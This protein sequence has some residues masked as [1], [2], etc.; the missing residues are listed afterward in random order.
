MSRKALLYILVLSF[1]TIL[2]TIAAGAVFN[3]SNPTAF[4]DALTAATGNNEDDTSWLPPALTTSVYPLFTRP[5]AV[6]ASSLLRRQIQQ[7]HL[8]LTAVEVSRS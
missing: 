8:C 7:T 1:I 3:V 2:P 6:M 4:Q 5:T